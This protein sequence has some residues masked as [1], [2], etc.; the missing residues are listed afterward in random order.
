MPD[1]LFLIDAYSLIFQVYYAIRQPMTGTR[2]QPTNAVFGFTG[3]IRHLLNDVGA[4]HV[5]CCMDSAHH[6]EVPQVRLGLYPA[7]KAQ[8]EEMPTD[9]VPQIPIILEMVEG[10]SIPIVQ[11]PGWEADDVLATLAKQGVAAGMQVR[12]VSSDK[13]C[14]Q[15]L[16]PS[17]SMYNIRKKQLYGPAEL[18]ADWGVSP[19]RVI[20]FQSLVGD[21]V[22]NV[23]GVPGVGP[24]KAQQ[25]LET[26]GTLDEVLANADRAPGK[27]L[28]ESLVTFA[29]QARVS[30]ELVTLNTDLPLAFDLESARITEP[31]HARL[32]EL[33]RD[34]GF[35][36]YADEAEKQALESKV[37]KDHQRVWHTV[38]TDEE[39][40]SFVTE[41]SRQ[42][43]VCID[44]ET[45]SQDA[46]RAEIVG[47]AVCWE[48]DVAWYLPVDGPPDDATLDGDVVLAAMRPI[49]ADPAIRIDNQNVKYDLLV[50]KRHGI[51]AAGIGV[52]PMLADYLLDAG[53]LQHGLDKLAKQYLHRSTIPISDLIGKGKQQK[54]MFEVAV[55]RAAEY[56]SEDADVALQLATLLEGQLR[57]QGLW[58]LYWDLERP[59][60]P[61]LVDM[62]HAGVRIDVDELGRQSNE[63]AT[64]LDELITEIH[65]LAGHVFNPDS[66]KQ[67]AVVLF[68]ELKLPARKRTKTGFSTDADV[69]EQL[70]ALHPLPEKVIEHRQ[71][72]KLRGTYLEALPRMVNPRTGNV[73][74][75]FNQAAAATG[76][77]SSSDPNL[78]N[79]PIRTAE[80]RRI[81]RAFVPS[82]PGWK[83][84][85]LDYSQIELRMLAHFCGDRVLLEAFASGTDVHT[86]VAAEIFGL[87]AAAVD[88]DQRRI[89][90]AVNFGVIYGQTPWGLA[91][92]LRISKEE[93][94]EFIEGYFARHVQI[95]EFIAET[96]ATCRETGYATT[97]LGRRR[98][99]VG[100]R[101][102]R[103][104]I[105]NLPE[106]TAV[107]TVVQGSAADLIKRA[108]IDVHARLKRESHP[109]RM[110]LQIH[111][112]LVFETPAAEVESLV[113]LV[114][115]EMT[116]ALELAVPLA[117][118]VGIGD[119]WLE[120]D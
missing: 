62:E 103:R 32:L 18:L 58:D 35:R 44:L 31:N 59:L 106:R 41:L 118:D 64:R 26:F 23:P 38:R 115:E 63:L 80:G 60:I 51:E 84:V 117:V 99:I 47:W 65:D 91:A 107:N 85:A 6:A 55:D 94:E 5:V 111:D 100:I 120:A 112:E 82:E 13:D 73:H 20:D 4:T 40:A 15:L 78:Q 3:D 72:T 89:A 113:E 70:A 33:F 102:G 50:L 42:N 7:Y 75:S 1:T 16:G 101:S 114:R 34:L 37:V 52:D 86:A 69:L 45:T 104:Q 2:G 14:R 53:A 8:R 88:K 97:I 90:K 11:H 66:P 10:F 68:E 49:L 116:G 43:R 74:A 95:D 12:I 61:V 96:L 25:L 119:N 93:A 67:L 87:D 77:L 21:S 81:R 46:M 56:A 24:K 22:D 57:E 83:Y 9:L 98:E 48:P 39:L 36:R 17:V 28:A 105:L 108:M 110:L 19:D 71:L 30:R 27:K 92:A 79:I 54:L 109:A 76:R 29:E